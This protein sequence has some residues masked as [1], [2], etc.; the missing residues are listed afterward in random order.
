M[1]CAMLY[2]A[3]HALPKNSKLGSF[4]GIFNFF[5][6]KARFVG[7]L[8]AALIFQ[9]GGSLR[10]LVVV[11]VSIGA[12]G[13]FTFLCIRPLDLSKLREGRPAKTSSRRNVGR[14]GRGIGCLRGD[15]NTGKH[16]SG[17]GKTEG[18]LVSVDCTKEE[19]E[20]HVVE[21][22]EALGG[23]HGQS[24]SSLESS[25]SASSSKS[26]LRSFTASQFHSG[27][28]EIVAVWKQKV[29]ML[30]IPIGISSGLTQTFVASEYATMLKDH[31]LKFYALAVEAFV[32]SLGSM[33]FGRAADKYGSLYLT[34]FSCA[35]FVAVCGSLVCTRS[36]L[37]HRRG[38]T[39]YPCSAAVSD[40]SW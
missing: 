16:G 29:F 23:E 3:D 17:G 33:A 15:D 20:E 27:K 28:D 18:G 21:H 37:G 13:S 7:S 10:T 8:T 9:F 6:N 40:S 12:C 22:S 26:M 32:T 30:L 34:V 24:K 31:T 19:T 39:L 35:V 36:V 2:K 4:N 1:Q 25:A 38:W 14:E 11:T 5:L